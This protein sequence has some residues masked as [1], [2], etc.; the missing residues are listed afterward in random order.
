MI[1]LSGSKSPLTKP[2]LNQGKSPKGLLN[3]LPIPIRMHWTDQNA[4]VAI[5]AVLSPYG[6]GVGREGV[7]QRSVWDY[8][9]LIPTYRYHED[10]LSVFNSH[11]A[12][13]TW[14]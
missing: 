12:R 1:R 14:D 4:H 8:F 5:P 3:H 6:Y 2:L 7:P 10:E 11:Q 9:A 13:V